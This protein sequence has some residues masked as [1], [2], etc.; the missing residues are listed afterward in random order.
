MSNCPTCKE[1]IISQTPSLIGNTVCNPDC[2]EDIS[3]EDIIPS[4]C[5]FYSG[6][7][8]SCPSGNTS[9][10][11]GDTITVALNK[12]YQLI[13]QNS[14]SNTV[15][16]TANDTCYGYLG[17]K[18]TS[19]TLDITIS[20]PGACEKLNLEEKCRTW[21]NIEANATTGTNKFR[22]K[23]RNYTVA[24]NQRVQIS[25]IKG[26]SVKL[27][28]RAY[29]S[30]NVGCNSSVIMVLSTAPLK[31]RV[32]SVNVIKVGASCPTVEPKLI[33]IDTFGNVSLVGEVLNG[34]Y[35]VS[36]DGIEFEIN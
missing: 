11:Y 31:D 27:R 30:I 34:S 6:A 21:T 5:V 3:C 10:N 26:C 22:N 7:T 32:F 9:V 15:Q 8:L 33:I 1:S 23:W 16:I 36:F 35:I 18:I 13:C 2:P 28:G 25:N 4:N 12:M 17:S 19:S 24:N 14:T 20:N 29:N